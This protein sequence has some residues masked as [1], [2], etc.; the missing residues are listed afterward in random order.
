LELR[1]NACLAGSRVEA[2]GGVEVERQRSHAW[3]EAVARRIP[4]LATVV[5]ADDALR[6]NPANT[7]PAVRGS[8][9]MLVTSAWGT[10]P[11]VLSQS[12]PPSRVMKRPPPAAPAYMVVGVEGSIATDRMAGFAIPDPLMVQPVP[13]LLVL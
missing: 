9:R 11:G 8:T 13:P 5:T 12:C 3:R 4:G 6:P 7:R 1:K 2:G 10:V